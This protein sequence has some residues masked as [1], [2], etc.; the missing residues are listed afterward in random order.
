MFADRSGWEGTGRAGFAFQA[1]DAVKLRG[2][3]YIGWR[4]P[5]LNELYRPFRVGADATAANELLTPERL[6]GGEIGAEFD[7]ADISLQA[8]AF[9][10]RL[11]NAIAN[12]SLGTGPGNFP[13]VGFVAVGGIYRQRQNLDA[14]DSRGIEIDAHYSVNESPSVRAMPM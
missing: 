2:A 6:K 1:S 10:N 8:T 3:A 5:T 11:D 13:G 9:Y 12:V 14:I 7:G 4:L